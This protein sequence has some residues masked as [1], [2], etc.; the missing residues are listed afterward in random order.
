LE[1]IKSASCYQPQELYY[2]H[3]KAKSSNAEVD[4]LIQKGSKIVPVEVKSGKKGSMQSLFL[5][6][7]S[8]K[9]GTGVRTSLENFGTMERVEI[10]PL[11]AI[12]SLT[13]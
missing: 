2:W 11:Y 7:E 8:K 9:I 6:L 12:C 10:Y 1:L 13:R 3:R 4:Y 5:F